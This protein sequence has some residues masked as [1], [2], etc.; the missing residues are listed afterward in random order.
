MQPRQ[1]RQA[2]RMQ[3]AWAGIEAFDLRPVGKHHRMARQKQV[4]IRN[5][6]Y[7]PRMPKPAVPLGRQ[8]TSR[9]KSA[10]RMRRGV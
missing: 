7:T 8:Q 3:G 4:V 9:R 10:A 2:Q 5:L 1:I 6:P